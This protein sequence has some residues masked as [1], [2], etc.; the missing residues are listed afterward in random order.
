MQFRRSEI[1]SSGAA[2][3]LSTIRSSSTLP[4]EMSNRFIFLSPPP[5][6][7]TTA[8]RRGADPQPLR[9]PPR[10]RCPELT[11]PRSKWESKCAQVRASGS[12]NGIVHFGKKNRKI[13]HFGRRRTK[14][15]AFCHAIRDFPS[16]VRCMRRR[17]SASELSK[18]LPHPP[19]A[20]D[21]AVRESS[22]L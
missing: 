14:R 6:L 7:R 13:A 18:P 8:R 4:A 3:L 21:V 20:V 12:K 19:T 16:A 1:I 9:P 22:T 17:K 11:D 10:F 5:P 2:R 15:S